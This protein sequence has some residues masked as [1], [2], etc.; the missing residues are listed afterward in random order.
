MDWVL[1]GKLHKLPFEFGVHQNSATI[2]S[3][4]LSG[5]KVD[6]V[7]D[8]ACLIK[9]VTNMQ[10]CNPTSTQPGIK[11]ESYGSMVTIWISKRVDDGR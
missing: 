4:G 1:F 10:C 8:T 6:C 7:F 11:S 2:R 3:F 9:H 5:A